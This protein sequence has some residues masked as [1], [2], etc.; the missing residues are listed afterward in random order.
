MHSLYFWLA[1]IPFFRQLQLDILGL[2]EMECLYFQALIFYFLVGM[3]SLCT[4]NAF[5]QIVKNCVY[6][7]F[8]Q[9]L[10]S[11]KMRGLFGTPLPDLQGGGMSAPSASPWRMRRSRG[12]GPPRFFLPYYEEAKNLMAKRLGLFL[13]RELFSSLVAVAC[14]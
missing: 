12:L 1:Y 3:F 6:V 7:L 9:A 14:A 10:L 5:Y 4:I 8:L 13:F 2:Q 11:A